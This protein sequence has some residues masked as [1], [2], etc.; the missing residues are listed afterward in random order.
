MYTVS[1]REVRIYF[2]AVSGHLTAQGPKGAA[3][4]LVLPQ[5]IQTVGCKCPLNRFMGLLSCVVT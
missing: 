4:E 5:V 3:D 1:S 2:K